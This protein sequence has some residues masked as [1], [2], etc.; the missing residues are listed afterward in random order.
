V[1]HYSFFL[2]L[3]HQSHLFKAYLRIMHLFGINPGF[4]FRKQ[5]FFQKWPHT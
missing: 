4:N 5:V 3:K 1:V 2:Y